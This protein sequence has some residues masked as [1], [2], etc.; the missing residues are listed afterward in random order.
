MKTLT[1]CFGFHYQL[2][3]YDIYF[4]E[5]LFT[6]G[7]LFLCSMICIFRKRLA[8]WVQILMALIL[9]GGIVLCFIFAMINNNAQSVV[10]P[11]FSENTRSIPF[12]QIAHIIALTPWAYVGFE[13][14]SHSTKEFRFKRKK[15]FRIM[16]VSV[17]TAGI[18]YILLSF[19]AVTALPEGYESWP[20][21]IRGLE[22][23]SGLSSLPTFFAAD[24]AMGRA[25]VI[26]LGVTVLG[27]IITGIIGNMI[28]ATRVLYAISKDEILPKRFSKTNKD[29]NP[30]NAI[31]FV[32][33]ISSVIPFFGRTAIS[34]IIDVTTVCSAIIYG[35]TSA[36]TFKKARST[37][38]RKTEVITGAAGVL[39]SVAFALYFL[40]PN[41]SSVNTL[42]TESYFILTVWSILGMLFFRRIFGKDTRR[43]FGKSI[44]VWIAL[45]FIILLT[46]IIWMQQANDSAIKDTESRIT[47]HYSSLIDKDNPSANDKAGF[48]EYVHSLTEDLNNTLYKNNLIHNLLIIF[49]AV[50]LFMVY[51]LIVK[52]QR[53]FDHVQ[54]MAYKDLMTK[55]GNNHAYRRTE[56]ML[57]DEI[58][59]GYITSFALAV[60]DLNGLKIIND[61][62]GHAKGDEFIKKASCIICEIF[63]HSPVY[64]I[65]GDEFVILLR[66]RD[67]DNRHKLIGK[68]RQ[69]NE[70]AKVTGGPVISVGM[71]DFDAN[72]DKSVDS[73]FARADAAMYIEKQILKSSEDFRQNNR[74]KR[75]GN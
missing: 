69:S 29:G 4:G 56:H 25:G 50:I 34:W 38:N 39:I 44:I 21:Y 32:T 68:I 18:A 14:V 63:S 1:F 58:A 17:I 47:S 16:I 23:M 33:V 61:T 55:T 15:A 41:L 20:S 65:G 5:I 28:A 52:R 73:I 27:G 59:R 54:D 51:S 60:C 10:D 6:L 75:S 46:S 62:L 74:T 13:S 64:R 31:I 48:E 43:R 12:M 57:N 26:I 67:F 9:I 66:G 11:A 8:V 30:V 24:S 37:P 70:S 35:Y 72:Y 19:L 40:I 49:A 3:G 71:A 53:E 36:A 7:V 22:D 42:A 2:A 45:L